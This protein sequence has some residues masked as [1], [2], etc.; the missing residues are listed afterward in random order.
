MCPEGNVKFQGRIIHHDK[1][2]KRV[3]LKDTKK[4]LTVD[5]NDFEN[6]RF[7]DTKILIT[8]HKGYIGSRLYKKL[9]ELGYTVHGIDFKQ[10]KDILYTNLPHVDVVFHLA[11]QSGAIPSMKDQCM[12]PGTIYFVH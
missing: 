7:N 3:N 6:V 12:M 11:A 5:P 8:G 10:G 4:Q 9:K 1:D 2:F